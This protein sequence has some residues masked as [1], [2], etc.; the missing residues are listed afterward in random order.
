MPA[1]AQALRLFGKMRIA[2]RSQTLQQAFSYQIEYSRLH[3]HIPLQQTKEVCIAVTHHYKHA[4]SSR[5]KHGR[6]GCF[7]WGR[8]IVRLYG[9]QNALL[10]STS[11]VC[12]SAYGFS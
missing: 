8:K 3:G 11:I 7:L 9:L 10:M 4:K 12:L 1:P 6:I 5:V 2:I